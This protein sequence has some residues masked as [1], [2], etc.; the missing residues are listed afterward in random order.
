MFE[1]IISLEN[2]L[3]SWRSFRKGKADKEDVKEFEFDLEDC[4]FGL[5]HDLANNTYRHGGY[6]SFYVHDPKLRHIHKPSVRDRIVHHAL[7]NV[8]DPMYEPTFIETS[9]AS[10]MGKGTHRGFKQLHRYAHEL[11]QNNTQTVWCLKSDIRKFFDS[12][13]H[14]VLMKILRR[15]VKDER[16]LGLIHEII[17]SFEKAPG[18]GLPLGNLTSQLFSNVYMNE[19]DQFVKRKLRVKHYARYADDLVVLSR[20]ETYLRELLGKIKE[21]LSKEL[22]LE[23]HPGKVKFVKWHAGIDFLGYVSFPHHSLVRAKTR[24]RMVKRIMAGV[25]GVRSGRMA[26][27]AFDRSL[28]SY[29]GVLSHAHAAKLRKRIKDLTEPHI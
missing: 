21:F 2:L 13:D 14:A 29:M 10:R 25:R 7:V 18:K 27:E 17:A 12:M 20:D 22:L 23:M 15:K 16:V 1:K 6:F 9:Y 26:Q 24:K 3:H 19:L 28:G 8:L 11:S 4:L 5:H